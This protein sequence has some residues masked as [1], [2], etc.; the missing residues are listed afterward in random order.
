MKL[1]TFWNIHFKYLSKI[2]L[3][4][5][6]PSSSYN[7]PNNTPDVEFKAPVLN[8]DGITL[9]TAIKENWQQ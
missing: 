5:I 6:T 8:V 1:D 3:L 2:I 7:I 9:S 4:E